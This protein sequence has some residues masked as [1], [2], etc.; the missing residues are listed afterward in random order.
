MSTREKIKLNRSSL[1]RFLPGYDVANFEST[2]SDEEASRLID[3]H[4]A[5]LKEGKEDE[6]HEVV[7]QIPAHPCHALTQ[8]VMLGKE[9]IFVLDM[10]LADAEK[11]Y[12]PDWM[13]RFDVDHGYT[14]LG[15][16]RFDV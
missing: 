14:R 10:N 6:A 3:L 8:L 5:L 7:R 16:R 9:D 12:G 13:D 15:G 4:Y 1:L 11:A 2:M